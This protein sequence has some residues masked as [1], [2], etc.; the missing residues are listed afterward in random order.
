MQIIWYDTLGREIRRETDGFD[1]RRIYNNT[2]YDNIGNI[3]RKSDPYFKNE[4]I[5]W[6]EFQYDAYERVIQE[7]APGNRISTIS[8][9][10]LKTVYTNP[11]GQK[12]IEIKNIIGKLIQTVNNTDD[13]LFM[14]YNSVGNLIQVKEL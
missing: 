10:A 1:G 6:S 14:S 7:T 2:E 12:N 3:S 8:Y 11:L 5:Y 9:Q 13:T 4:T